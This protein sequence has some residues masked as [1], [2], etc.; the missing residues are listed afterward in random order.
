MVKNSGFIASSSFSFYNSFRITGTMHGERIGYWERGSKYNLRP[1]VGTTVTLSLRGVERSAEQKRSLPGITSV[2]GHTRDFFPHLPWRN[3]TF[4]FL[5]VCPP[6][7]T[8]NQE[9]WLKHTSPKCPLSTGPCQGLQGT[10]D[11]GQFLT[12]RNF[13]QMREKDPNN[14]NEGRI[15]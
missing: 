2:T 4:R 13:S 6:H 14:R 12:S 11:E 7:L 15:C 1:R 5:C 8:L 3:D 9:P 10:H